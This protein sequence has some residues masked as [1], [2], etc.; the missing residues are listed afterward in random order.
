MYKSCKITIFI[1]FFLGIFFSASAQIGHGGRPYSFKKS[2]S[3][4]PLNMEFLSYLDN[5][6][7]LKEEVIPTK[8]E[9]FI[10]GKEIDVDYSL[11]NAGLWDTLSNGARLWRLGIQSMGAYSLNLLFDSFYIPPFSNL[12]I[13]T[14]DKS[15]VI[16][17][18]TGENNNRWGN[19]ATS[20]LPGDAIVLEYYEA[21]QDQGLGI[22]N[23]S[24]VVHG[25]KDFF[26]KR[27]IYGSSEKCNM[28][29]NCSIGSMYPNAK[30]AVAL[31]LRGGSAHC[32]GTLINNTAQDG[33][34][35]FLTANHCM[36]SNPSQ[37]VFVFN[38]ES[39]GCGESTAKPSYSINGATLLAKHPHSDFALL[40]LN[41]IPP[42]DSLPYY[43]GW[44]RR[45]IAVAGAVCIH[46]PNGD[47]K[48]ISKDNKLLDSS[49]WEDEDPSYPKN[50]HWEVTYWD[51]GT[52]QG[53]SSGSALFNV[54]E[55][56]I[57][58]LEGGI[59]ECNG[60]LPNDGYDLFGKVSYSWTNGNSPDSNRLDYWLDPLGT[61]I[62][63]LN[64]Y[65]PYENVNTIRFEQE[66]INI[67]LSPNPANDIVR[68]AANTQIHSYK[69]Y[70]VNGQRIRSA[71]INSSM[72][73]L[74]VGDL[75]SGVFIIE[76]LTDKGIVFKKLFIQH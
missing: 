50:T 25:Y 9:G 14:E 45:N 24:T 70:A 43:A 26:F 12:F 30:R 36:T 1:G 3:L 49:N 15:Y 68:I 76:L 71:N 28:D 19:F 11:E 18:F 13:Y 56:I 75:T 62:E 39:T 33:K 60:S 8:E 38:Y 16:G 4:S 17:S 51:S 7:L 34:P 67:L 74:N 29:V 20:L 66:I 61:G 31:I 42:K 48:K 32:S 64:G 73:D 41:N 6:I 22:L 10:F 23:L 47:L 52:T 59:A 69:I 5:E 53:G 57:G 21:S 72:V 44:D 2:I 58:Q 55:Q 63:V 54:L 65:D 46:H 37:F 35:Y 27:G 40:L